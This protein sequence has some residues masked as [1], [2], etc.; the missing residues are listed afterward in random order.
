M[1][2]D[3]EN[4]SD[5]SVENEAKLKEIDN[6]IEEELKELKKVFYITS[7]RHINFNRKIEWQNQTSLGSHRL[8]FL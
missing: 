6:L 8:I 2:D 1:I 4:E 7:P 5:F 3:E